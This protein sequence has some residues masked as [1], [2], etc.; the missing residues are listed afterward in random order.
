MVIER[1]VAGRVY[2]RRS[3]ERR[4]CALCMNPRCT[5]DKAVNGCVPCTRRQRSAYL[6]SLYC[7]PALYCILVI[8]VHWLF[9][10]Q[11]RFTTS[12]SLIE[13]L[14]SIFCLH[15]IT[16]TAFQCRYRALSG[17]RASIAVLALSCGYCAWSRV[18]RII[19]P[20]VPYCIHRAL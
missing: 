13:C 20:M 11:R 4:S 10:C 3:N 6:P 16:A 9:I 7:A 15:S 5:S 12:R 18:S 8:F 14:L 17:Y 2:T 19:A 1:R